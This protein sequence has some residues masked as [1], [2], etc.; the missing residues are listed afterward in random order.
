MFEAHPALSEGLA[1]QINGRH[2]HDLARVNLGLEQ[3]AIDRDMLHMSVDGGNKVQRLHHIRAV[4]AGQREIGFE[5]QL[6]FQALCLRQHIGAFLRR[7]T[8]NLQQRED[9]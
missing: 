3:R 8:A 4:L 2:G 7:M 9:Q 6:A 5:T 1:I